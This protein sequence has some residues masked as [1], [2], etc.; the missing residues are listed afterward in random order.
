MKHYILLLLTCITLNVSAQQPC[1][2]ALYQ[3]LQHKPLDSM[4]VR[5]YHYFI[6]AQKKCEESNKTP[7]V[8][9][10]L[11]IIAF[12]SLVSAFAFLVPFML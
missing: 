3:R 9:H 8:V 12:T 7:L 5:E 11:T 6:D 2:D 4:T 1:K 10:V